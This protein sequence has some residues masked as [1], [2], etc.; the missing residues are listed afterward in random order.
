M[1]V[2]PI[3]LFRLNSRIL[4]SE[5]S[6]NLD[7]SDLLIANKIEKMKYITKKKAGTIALL[8]FWIVADFE[9]SFGRALLM[10]ALEYLVF[11]I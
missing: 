10:N 2:S 9:S 11:V 3:F 6:K 1:C 5:K 7:L 8:T 4:N